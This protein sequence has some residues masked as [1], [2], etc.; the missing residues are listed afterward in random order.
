MIKAQFM[1]LW[2]GLY[3]RK[4]NCG[5]I[6]LGA[7][8][9]PHDV[10]LAIL[11]RM[12]ATFEIPM[13]NHYQRKAIL[14]LLLVNEPLESDVDIE[15]LAESTDGFSA[16]DLKELCR[17]AV[18]TRVR[19]KSSKIIKFLSETKVCNAESEIS[20]FISKLRNVNT[21]DFQS[22]LA[23]MKENKYSCTKIDNHSCHSC[24]HNE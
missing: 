7:T 1:I 10:D 19:E 21:N 2:D 22:A 5:I 9:R 24:T 16:S 17:N 23:R 6:V 11:R 8:N 3:S 13:P 12:P 18:F 20:D 15:E 14:N 4:D